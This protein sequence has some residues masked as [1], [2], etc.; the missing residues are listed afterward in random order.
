MIILEIWV[1]V[2]D[3]LIWSFENMALGTIS[4][5]GLKGIPLP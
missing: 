3:I 4:L 5:A 1:D 2:W